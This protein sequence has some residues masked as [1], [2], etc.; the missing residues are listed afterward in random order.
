VKR[1]AVLGSTGSIGR[2]ALEVI[3]ASGGELK[4]HSLLCRSSTGLLAEQ[5]ARWKPAVVAVTGGGVP[6]W[7]TRAEDPL[8]AAIEGA[9]IVLNAITGSAG[10]RA[11]LMTAGL[12]TVLALANKESLVIG[13]ELLRTHIAAGR[14][15]PVDSE[16]S[17]IWRCIRGESPPPVSLVL[18]ASGGAL[19]GVPL[20]EVTNACPEAVL[21]HPTW[22]MGPRIT[23]DSATLVNKAFEVIEARWLFPGM[24]VDVVIHPA[25][26]V[27]SL[28]RLADGSM[29]ALMGRPDMRIPIQAALLGPGAVP[30]VTASDGPLDWPALTFSRVEAARYPAFRMVCDA[31]ARGGTFPAAANAADEV[32]VQAFLEGRIRLGGIASVIEHALSRCESCAGVNRESIEEADRSARRTA[33]EKVESLS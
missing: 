29:K 32:A 16:H 14:L 28:V 31:G 27:H 8:A 4:V 24:D 20:D 11:S 30:G 3:G 25:S 17:T 21:K 26:I 15:V 18:T 1:V 9:D 22:D 7:A 13:G 12:G 6:H 2:Q 19:R 23:V 5:A 33:L 10:L